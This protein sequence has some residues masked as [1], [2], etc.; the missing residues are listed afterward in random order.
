MVTEE[1]KPKTKG[2]RY[3]WDDWLYCGHKILTRGKDFDCE[4]ASMGLIVR[5]ALKSRKMNRQIHVNGDTVTIDTAPAKR[6]RRS[7]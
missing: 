3:P 2:R 1:P 5:L 6:Y 7:K 4:P